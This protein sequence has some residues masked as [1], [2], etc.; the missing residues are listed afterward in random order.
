MLVP[1]LPGVVVRSRV[2]EEGQLAPGA[3]LGDEEGPVV[4]REGGGQL[5]FADRVQNE[6]A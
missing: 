3:V 4:G 2:D 5:Q 1:V 6:V